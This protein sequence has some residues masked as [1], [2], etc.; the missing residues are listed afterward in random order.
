MQAQQ[1]RELEG[2]VQVTQQLQVGCCSDPLLAH[3]CAGILAA[4]QC[5]MQW[6]Q[7]ACMPFLA[8]CSAF[9]AW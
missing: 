5:S 6:A 9:S 1:M 7:L 8:G 2:H 3:L 4:C